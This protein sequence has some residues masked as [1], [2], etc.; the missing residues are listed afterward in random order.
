MAVCVLVT[1]A[2]QVAP[3]IGHLHTLL[4]LELLHVRLVLINQVHIT[5]LGIVR[6]PEGLIPASGRSCLLV[7]ASVGARVG[8]VDLWH[9]DL[10]VVPLLVLSLAAMTHDRAHGLVVIGIVEY[11]GLLASLGTC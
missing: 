10:I 9:V 3:R 1:G 2:V 11:C 8:V 7:V 5:V 6:H 4:L